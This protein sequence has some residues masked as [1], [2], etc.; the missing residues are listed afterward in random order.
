[1]FRSIEEKKEQEKQA[2]K[3]RKPM[4]PMEVMFATQEA[5]RNVLHG[6]NNTSKRMDKTGI[7]VVRLAAE[8]GVNLNDEQ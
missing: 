2:E 3:A 7:D 1:M 6:A 4:T 8:C 5:M